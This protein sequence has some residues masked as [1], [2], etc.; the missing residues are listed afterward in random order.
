[1]IRRRLM[2][3]T[4]VALPISAVAC[5]GGT[6]AASPRPSRPLPSS[7]GDAVIRPGDFTATVDNPWF[8]LAPGT[9]LTYKGTKDGKPTTEKMVVTG[10]ITTIDGV[11]CATVHDD[12]YEAGRLEER[13]TDWYTQD[14]QSN[15]WYFGE[16]T[17]ELDAKG[18]VTSTEGSWQAGKGGAR[19]G[20]FMPARPAVGQSFR[21]EYLKGHAEDHF[22]VLRLGAPVHVPAVSSDQ[23]LLTKEW[24]PVEPGVIDHK[25]Y[26]RGIGTVLEQ[27]AA[28]P[29]ETN[30]LVSFTKGP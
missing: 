22:Q 26:V 24:T 7:P 2:I 20:I 9:T 19:P 21:Q 10:A 30:T 14:R 6:N 23:A 15:V 18:R 13:T 12:L 4:L 11:P 28:G 29:K 25:Y 5:G 3:V 17:A 16:A 27:S 1:V 8:P